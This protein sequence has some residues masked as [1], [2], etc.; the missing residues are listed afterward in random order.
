MANRNYNPVRGAGYEIVDLEGYF[1]PQGAGAVVNANNSAQWFSV[2]RTGVGLY[3]ITF[4]SKF[5]DVYGYSFAVTTTSAALG[6]NYD[7]YLSLPTGVSLKSLVSTT[8]AVPIAIY[9]KNMTLAGT[10]GTTVV[11]PG[12]PP[13]DLASSVFFKFKMKNST[14]PG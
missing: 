12:D 8:R 14:V 7:V 1:F 6:I 5:V 13:A 9:T 4:E 10:P 11:V 3:T 2:A